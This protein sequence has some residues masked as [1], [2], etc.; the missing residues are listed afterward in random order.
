MEHDDLLNEREW[1][2]WKKFNVVRWVGEM[3]V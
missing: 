2:F 1:K 3:K